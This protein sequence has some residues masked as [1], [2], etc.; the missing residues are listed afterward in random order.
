MGGMIPAIEAGYPQAKIAR[1]QLRVPAIDRTGEQ[2]IVGVNA[3]RSKNDE[4]R[5]RSCR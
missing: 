4:R 3:F 5:F 1:G 2:I